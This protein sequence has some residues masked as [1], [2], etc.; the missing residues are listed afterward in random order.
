MK[1]QVILPKSVEKELDRL[2]DDVARRIMLRLLE[3]VLLVS[4]VP[5]KPVKADQFLMFLNGLLA[6]SAVSLARSLAAKAMRSSGLVGTSTLNVC[7]AIIF[8]F[9]Y[10]KTE[11]P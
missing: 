10:L 1:Y 9:P 2:P 11:E 3:A 6:P 4:A 7:L 5:F 8:P